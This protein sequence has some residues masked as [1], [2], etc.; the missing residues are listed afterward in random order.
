MSLSELREEIDEGRRPEP[1]DHNPFFD[2]ISEIAFGG[3]C[4]SDNEQ[5]L[6]VVV[7][8]II[9]LL[10]ADI[11]SL[12]FWERSAQVSELEGKLLRVF[13]LS[14]VEELKAKREYLVTEVMA[15][16]KRRE[17]S[18]LCESSEVDEVN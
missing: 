2:L 3:Q 7:E 9:E 16:A 14:K 8:Q 17:K 13:V 6:T 15:L 18:I 1:D 11:R 4:S 5:T 12:N 10:A